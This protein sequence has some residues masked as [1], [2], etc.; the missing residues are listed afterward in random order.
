MITNILTQLTLTLMSVINEL[1]YIGILIGMAIESSFFPFPS[2]VI[3]IPAGVLASQ[4]KMSLGIIFLMAL[5]GS[6]IGA[7][8][9]YFLAMYL[10]RTTIDLLIS[11]YKRILFLNKEK[12]KQSDKYFQKYGEITTF[13]G[14]LVP[15]VRQLISLPAGFSRMNLFKFCIFTSLGAGAWAAILIY[16]GY[17]CGNNSALIQENLHIITALLLV[18]AGIIFV[19]YFLIKKL[20]KTN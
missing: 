3:L 20:K 7:L 13:V 11:K 17:L 2:E 1:G 16:I 14:R 10:G 8:V 9:N 6:L 5:I 12:I 19:L 18:L 15:V 4:G